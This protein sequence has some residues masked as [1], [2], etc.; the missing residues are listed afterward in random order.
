MS[1]TLL[2]PTV[3]TREALRLLK[4]NL[5]F[6]KLVFRKFQDEF[7]KVGD[8]INVRCPVRIKSVAGPDITG[9]IQNIEERSIPFVLDIWRTVP[10]EFSVKDLTL[11]VEEFGKRYLRSGCATLANDIDSTLANLY[12][13]VFNA[14][15]LAGTTPATFAALGDAATVL[16]NFGVP[17][18]DRNLVL[19]PKANW[20]M[21]DA[22]KG[23]FV[24]KEVRDMV[25]KGFLARVANMDIHTDQNVVKHTKGTGA[26]SPTMSATAGQTGAS[27]ATMGWT[28]NTDLSK[29]DIF[30]ILGVN[31]VNPS[32]LQD[33]GE[34][35]QFVVTADIVTD[36]AAATMTIPIAP[37]IEITGPYQT[38]TAAP[39][40]SAA[41]TLVGSHVA[42]LAFFREAFGLAMVKTEVPDGVVWA[43]TEQDEGFSISVI[44]DYDVLTH[45]QITR[46]DVFFGVK[47]LDANMACRLLG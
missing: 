26:G 41:L 37:A 32:N 8:T 16:D 10:L 23:L 6:A 30:T 5:V 14:A 18:I 17:T 2:T 43:S 21:A 46:L 4:N 44:K 11:T 40:G 33:T 34:L 7:H 35:Q 29:G 39:A 3:I 20:S 31:S 42:N 13:D 38:V 28:N 19:N 9:K 22:L 36:A 15:G 47:T 12:V 25:S 1:S 24:Q 45:K 27:I